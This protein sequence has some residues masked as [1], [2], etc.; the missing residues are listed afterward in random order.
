MGFEECQHVWVVGDIISAYDEV[1]D[2]SVF[3]I[4]FETEGVGAVGDG[5]GLDELLD[6]GAGD[7]MHF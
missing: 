4:W 6:S 2:D 3:H 1:Y 5:A 7:V